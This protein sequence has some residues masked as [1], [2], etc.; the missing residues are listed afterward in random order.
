MKQNLLFYSGLF[1]ILLIII[2]A[3]FASE[4]APYDPAAI[5]VKNVLLPPSAAHL[6]GTDE[7]GR[8]VL[9]RLIFGTRISIKVGFIAVGISAIIGTILGAIAGFFEGVADIAIMRFVDI[10]LCFPTFFLILAVIA[11]LEPSIM[12]I[13]LIIGLT[14]WM[15]ICRMVRAEILSLKKRE[16]ILAAVISGASNF[17]ILM[18]HILP[19]VL[20]IILVYATLGIGGAILTESALSFLGLGVQ[21]PTASWGNMLMSGKDNIDIAWWLSLFPGLAIF[22]TIL[23]FNFVGEGLQNLLNPKNKE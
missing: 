4:I 9:S 2:L 18:L 16:F 10:M 21:P 23:A 19:N 13:M 8:D 7:L 22:V 1:V 11:Y 5:N 14:S 15:G 6:L 17:R 20:P 12:N 3:I